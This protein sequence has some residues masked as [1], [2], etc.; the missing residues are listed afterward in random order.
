MRLAWLVLLAACNG[1]PID[2]PQKLVSGVYYVTGRLESNDCQPAP[3]EVT[4]TQG[5][6]D[7]APEGVNLP[8][9]VPN[10]FEKRDIIGE[11][12]SY[13]WTVCGAT[14]SWL[15]QRISADSLTVQRT[16]TWSGVAGVD[17]SCDGAGA[18]PDADCTDVDEVSYQLKEAC[19]CH[20][21]IIV[22]ADVSCDCP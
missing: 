12:A 16:E 18:V 13:D 7:V 11:T 21:Y 20:R 3:V 2:G 22:G 10:G 15:L 6:V 8:L 1:S 14:R 19:D 9:P 17:W 4:G 5:I